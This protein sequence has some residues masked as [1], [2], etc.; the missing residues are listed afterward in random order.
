M[1]G[2]SQPLPPRRSTGFTTQGLTFWIFASSSGSQ[3]VTTSSAASAGASSVTERAK[4]GTKITSNSTMGES[5][6]RAFSR[7]LERR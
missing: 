5:S 6:L 1:A 4:S 3:A 2:S 7:A